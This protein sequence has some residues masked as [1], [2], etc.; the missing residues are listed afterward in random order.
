[1]AENQMP[2]LV[3]DQC[4]TRLWPTVSPF[5][6]SPVY[7]CGNLSCRRHFGFRFGYFNVASNPPL[8]ID[9]AGRNGASCPEKREE[10]LYMALVR[11]GHGISR[12]CFDCQKHFE[13][14]PTLTPVGTSLSA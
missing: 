6:V 8:N 5:A 1:M 13:D 4:S 14:E 3:C 9:P 7:C 2:I 10:H 12:Y 11:R